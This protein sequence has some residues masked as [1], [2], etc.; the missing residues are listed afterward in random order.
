MKVWKKACEELK[1]YM[2]RLENTMRIKIERPLS[3]DELKI[4]TNVLKT[5]KEEVEKEGKNP[6]D[7]DIEL[8]FF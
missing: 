8:W 4:V 6:K 2:R 3:D 5:A 7:I 1:D